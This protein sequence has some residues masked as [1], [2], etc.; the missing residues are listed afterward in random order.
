ML[1]L[2]FYGNKKLRLAFEYGL[3]LSESAKGQNKEVTSEMMKRGEE[4]LVKEFSS[5]SPTR[6][7]TEMI[8][9]ILAMMEP[10][11]KIKT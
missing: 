2:P 8:P 10:D 1:K 9:N 7:S 4:I 6:L 3:V 5:K 11:D